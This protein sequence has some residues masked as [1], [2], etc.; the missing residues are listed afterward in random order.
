MREYEV[1][2]PSDEFHKSSKLHEQIPGMLDG[3]AVNLHRFLPS[4]SQLLVKFRCSL[5]RSRIRLQKWPLV[6][7]VSPMHIL[8]T[9]KPCEFFDRSDQSVFHRPHFV[10]FAQDEARGISDFYETVVKVVCRQRTTPMTHKTNELVYHRISL[11]V[12][13]Q[14]I[15]EI[16]LW[17]YVSAVRFQMCCLIRSKQIAVKYSRKL[18]VSSRPSSSVFWEG[19]GRSISTQSV[20]FEED[21]N[22][23]RELSRRRVYNHIENCADPLT[24]TNQIHEERYRRS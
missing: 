12:T 8:M 14:S 5:P 10:I 3:R 21:Y 16:A 15:Y 1:F 24:S 22:G 20:L 6:C 19:L 2:G 18:L 9:T 13:Y 23:G 17:Y 4:N 7:L 11:L